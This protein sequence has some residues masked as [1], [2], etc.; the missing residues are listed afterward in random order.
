MTTAAGCSGAHGLE[1]EFVG[2][3]LLG[4]QHC[5]GLQRCSIV[6]GILVIYTYATHYTCIYTYTYY[7]YTIYIHILYIHYVH[8]PTYTIFTVY[9]HYNTTYTGLHIFIPQEHIHYIHTMH[10]LQQHH[11]H[12]TAHIYSSGTC[13][14]SPDPPRCSSPSD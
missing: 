11:L 9:I 8:T 2:G 5:S 10:T 1:S 6:V 13:P 4:Q 3:F 12:W 7:T 14:P